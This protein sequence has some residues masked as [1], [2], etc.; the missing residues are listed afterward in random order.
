MKPAAPVTTYLTA[1]PVGLECSQDLPGAP[2][3]RRARHSSAALHER[4]GGGTREHAVVDV[5]GA[6]DPVEQ[7]RRRRG[8]TSIERA[9]DDR[10]KAPCC[11]LCGGDG[12]G[13]AP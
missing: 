13:D 3:R 9:L 12:R 10:A 8:R 6:L 2:E 11:Q 5:E 1:C 7:D 4:G